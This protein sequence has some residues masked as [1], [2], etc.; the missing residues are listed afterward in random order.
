MNLRAAGSSP[1]HRAYA[2]LRLTMGIDGWRA[3]RRG[4][5]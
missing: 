3:G 1:P 2:P 4:G 5:G